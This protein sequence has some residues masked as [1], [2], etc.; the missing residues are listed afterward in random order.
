MVAS[1]KVENS[2]REDE[3][4]DWLGFIIKDYAKDA[5]NKFLSA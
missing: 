4:V 2:E 5:D 1:R 3:S